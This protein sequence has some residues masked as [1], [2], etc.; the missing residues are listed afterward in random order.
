MRHIILA[1]ML[2]VFSG[3]MMNVTEMQYASAVKQ[4][5]RFNVHSP[6]IITHQVGDLLTASYIPF[7]IEMLQQRGFSAVY[8]DDEIH[9]T[10]ARNIVFVSLIKTTTTIPTSS[11]TY[12]P[13]KTINTSSCFNYDRMYYCREENLPIITSYTSK[14]NLI[15]GYHFIMDWYD[16][17]MQ[18]RILYIDG[19]VNDNPC[20]YEGIYKD[21]IYQTI[22]RIDFYRPEVYTYYTPLSYYTMPCI[23]DGAKRV[24]VGKSN[25]K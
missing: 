4:D 17:P 11:V 22:S 24:M 21:L 15:S 12:I 19:S 25:A 7:I 5:Y 1:L 23:I 9:R 18:K 16:L 3:C 20:I 14:L 8:K 6:I 13:T 10:K 2:L